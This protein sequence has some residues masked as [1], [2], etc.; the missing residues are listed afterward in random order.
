[1][2]NRK[3]IESRLSEFNINK[4]DLGSDDERPQFDKMLKQA[5]SAD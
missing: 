1:M 5:S 2:E 4:R 3:K